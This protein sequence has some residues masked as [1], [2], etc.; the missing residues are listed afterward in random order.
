MNRRWLEAHNARM[1]SNASSTTQNLSSMIRLRNKASENAREHIQ[2][3]FV[4]Y[5][6]R[7]TWQV[8]DEEKRRAK[9]LIWYYR[10]PANLNLA[11]VEWMYS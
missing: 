9:E 8:I 3:W 1:L 6:L 7:P 4:F 10:I 11:E 2:N 5:S